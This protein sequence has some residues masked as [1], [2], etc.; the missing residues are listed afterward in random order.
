M[1]GVTGRAGTRADAADVSPDG[2]PAW[3]EV[4]RDYGRFLYTLAFRL[5]A[6]R[7]DAEDLVQETLLRVRRGLRTYQPG[8]MEGWLT[9]I[10]T[11]CFIDQTRR[12]PEV[13]LDDDPDRD[14]GAAPGADDDLLATSISADVQAALMALPV[15]Y[16]VPVVL[17]D[18][19]GRS[20]E[21]IAETL[22]V[23]LGTVRSRIH[24]GRSLLRRALGG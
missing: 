5:T 21:E 4:A 24:R 8:S 18:V 7:Q 3:E 2:I 12:R 15:E 9:R 19:A 22:S 10:A 14:L 23:P 16:R 1:A 17:C 20:Y 13:P 11:N 6:D